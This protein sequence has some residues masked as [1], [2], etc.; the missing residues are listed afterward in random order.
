MSPLHGERVGII[1]VGALGLAVA[2]RLIAAGFAVSGFRRGGLD[3]FAAAGGRPMLS[4]Q[5][6]VR[7][8]DIV[9]LFLPNDDALAEVMGNI[10]PSLKRGHVLLCLGTHALQRK[11]EAAR[12]AQAAGAVLLDGE[13]SGTPPMVRSG[14][15]SVMLSGDPE[16]AERVQPIL[17]AFAHATTRLAAFGDAT[18]MKLV[19]NYLVSVHTLAAAE[20]LHLGQCLGLDARSVVEAI[21]PSA[22]GSTMLS[23]RGTMMVEGTFDGGGMA[24][25]VRFFELLRAALGNSSEAGWPL[26]N[27]TGQLYRAAIDQGYGENDIAAIYKSLRPPSV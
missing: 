1:G 10:A 5:A 27:L 22:G 11:Q 4:A 12:V 15:A 8:A 20:A 16:T 19:T 9:I 14:R 23:V 18:R 13:V 24:G 7:E 3:A 6:L 21:A 17:S 26:M 2:E 25:F